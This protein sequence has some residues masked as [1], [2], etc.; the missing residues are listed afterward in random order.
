MSEKERL[1]SEWVERL[2][3]QR[4][5]IKAMLNAAPEEFSCSDEMRAGEAEWF[6]VSRQA[7]IRI[8]RKEAYADPEEY[9]FELTLVHELLHLVFAPFYPST[10]DC[11]ETVIHCTIEDLANA[12][13]DAKYSGKQ[14]GGD[15][16]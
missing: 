1:F 3:L 15:A 11:L 14:Q 4:W 9:H 8:L 12:L 2:G 6:T 13:V 5:K 7:T 16:G 10:E